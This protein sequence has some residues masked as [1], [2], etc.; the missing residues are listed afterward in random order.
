MPGRVLSA[1]SVSVDARDEDRIDEAVC[2]VAVDGSA[3]GGLLA[4][5]FV[6]ARDVA[7][8]QVGRTRPCR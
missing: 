5:D 4:K 1:I 7:E 3:H 6:D 8:D 2:P